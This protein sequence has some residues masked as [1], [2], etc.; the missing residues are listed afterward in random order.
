MI[1]TAFKAMV[2][3]QAGITALIGSGVDARLYPEILPQNPVYPAM[4][5][6]VISGPRAYHQDGADGTTTFRVQVDMYDTDA[7]GLVALRDAVEA[8]LSGLYNETFLQSPPVVVQGVFIINERSGF[9][10]VVN[11]TPPGAPYRKIMDLAV[12][13]R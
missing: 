3:A 9:L 4:T 11:S 2:E 6:Q 1:E 8:A 12:T 5:Y 13:V 10:S 7:D